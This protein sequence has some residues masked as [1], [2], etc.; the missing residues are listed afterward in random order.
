MSIRWRNRH[1]PIAHLVAGLLCG[2]A[3]LTFAAK[4]RASWQ[5]AVTVAS[6][7]NSGHE[8]GSPTPGDGQ[9]GRRDLY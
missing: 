5:P 4:A 3:L 2:F 8:V 9:R 7:D 6:G 1:F